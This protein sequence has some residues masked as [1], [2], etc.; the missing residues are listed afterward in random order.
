MNSRRST[1]KSLISFVL[2]FI[3]GT[4]FLAASAEKAQALSFSAAVNYAVR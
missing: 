4:V 3:L 1:K 2:Y